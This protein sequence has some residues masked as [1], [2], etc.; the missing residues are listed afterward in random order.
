MDKNN[1]SSEVSE[2][3]LKRY[4]DAH[5]EEEAYYQEQYRRWL[6]KDTQS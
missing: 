6:K 3:E 1:L 5:K 4:L 2:E